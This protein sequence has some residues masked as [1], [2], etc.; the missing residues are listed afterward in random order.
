MATKTP[1]YYINGKHLPSNKAVVSISDLGF[2]RSFALFEA[3]RTYDRKPF[4]LKPHLD[5]MFSTAAKIRIRPPLSQ[6]GIERVINGLLKKNKFPEVLIRIYLTGGPTQGLMP[7]GKP[8]LAVLVDPLHLFAPW[9]YEKG[10]SLMTTPFARVHPEMKSTV[11]FSAV[12]RSIEATRR[13]FTEVVYVDKKGSILE[14]TTFNVVAVLPGPRLV[15]AKDQVLAG[16]TINHV[17]KLAKQLKIPV[18]RSS[19]SRSQ[20]NRAQEVFITS[21]NRELIPVVRVDRLKIGNGK[22]GSVTK[23]L[24]QAYRNSIS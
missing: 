17:F 7:C 21:S 20:L 5:R 6:S 14:G 3:L 9:Q 22:P 10:I 18:E 12:Y 24:H 16:V 4:L 11:Y 8:S 23:Q 2:A 15:A 19:I 1:I 13:G